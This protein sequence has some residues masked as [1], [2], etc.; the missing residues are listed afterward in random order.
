MRNLLQA[1]MRATPQRRNVL[2]R[3]EQSWGQYQTIQER[4]GKGRLAG[5]GHA[6]L[7]LPISHSGS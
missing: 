5:R 2:L 4:I 1:R 6:T 7:S 3:D